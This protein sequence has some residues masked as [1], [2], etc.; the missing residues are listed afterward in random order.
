MAVTAVTVAVSG[1]R[2]H[3]GINTLVD[4][5]L[6]RKFPAQRGENGKGR[7]CTGKSGDDLVVA[8][9]VGTM[10][11]EED[12]GELIGDLVRDGQR[13]LVARGGFHGLG[14]ARF[15]SSTNRTPRQ[16]SP[17]RRASAGGC[18]WS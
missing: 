13:L 18:S 15:K 2:P 4:F 17:V 6:S 16:S 7:N 5:R 12:T 1:S 3:A 14:N 9:P 8:V 11:H 10:V